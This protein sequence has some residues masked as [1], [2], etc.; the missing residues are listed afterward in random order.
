MGAGSGPPDGAAGIPELAA[1]IDRHVQDPWQDGPVILLAAALAVTLAETDA[2]R[3]RIA[4]TVTD[5]QGRPVGGLSA[6][7]FE[8]N[9]GKLPE[10]AKLGT[11]VAEDGAN[12]ENF[13]R[14]AEPA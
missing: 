5:R 9:L 12:R 11:V 14:L 7:D 4:T 13:L 1:A 2:G 6:K 8:I 3:V 10:A